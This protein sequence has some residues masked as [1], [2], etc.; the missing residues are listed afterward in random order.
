[1]PDPSST[2]LPCFSNAY[3]RNQNTKNTIENYEKSSVSF[4]KNLLN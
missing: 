3:E 1:M 4:T 2:R